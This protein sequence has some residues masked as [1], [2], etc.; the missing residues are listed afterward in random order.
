MCTVAD[1]NSSDGASVSN[2]QGV[3]ANL[4][5]TRPQRA[6]ARRAAARDGARATPASARAR[7]T[8]PRQRRASRPRPA[9]D[10]KRSIRPQQTAPV[11]GFECD[12]EA[13]SGSVHPPGAVELLTSAA[14][15]VSELAKAGVSRSERLLKDVISRFPL[16]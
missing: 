16:S 1:L 7:S 15:V 8:P 2:E 14:E 13:T 10:A 3:L 6:S 5:R 12:S 4:P 9:S 11:Q